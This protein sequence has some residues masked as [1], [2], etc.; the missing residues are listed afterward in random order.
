LKKQEGEKGFQVLG[1]KVQDLRNIEIVE[2]DLRGKRFVE[3]NGNNGAA[4]STLIDGLF[5]ALIGRKYFGGKLAWQVI[6]KGEDKAL[7]KVILGN[8]ER[9]IEV[10]R[11]ITKLPREGGAVETGGSLTITD[12]KGEKLDQDFLDGLLSELT[13]DPLAFARKDPREQVEVVK[14]LAGLD[15]SRLEAQEASLREERTLVN[16]ELK[17][18]QGAAMQLV[19]EPADPVDVAGLNDERR[20]MEEHNRVQR[21]RK[22]DFEKAQNKADGIRLRIV[23]LQNELAVQMEKGKAIE[24]ELKGLT[25]PEPLKP[26]DAVDAA[27][28]DAARQ[29]RIAQRYQEYQAARKAQE[30]KGAESEALSKKI[31]EVAARRMQAIK[32]AKLPFENVEFS[33]ELGLVIGG[34]PFSQ[35]SDAEKLRISTRIGM[36]LRPDF[37]IVF[38]REGS[39]LDEESYAVVRDLA[40]R[41]G[42]QV[43]VE[44]V[45]ERRG[46]E[47][48]VMRAG[49]AV[50]QFE[51]VETRAEKADRLTKEL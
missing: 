37:R 26:T 13:V 3:I 40:G 31:E 45:G 33:Q 43:L 46:E 29:N 49:E 28:A 9:E 21:E 4:K 48:I 14:R 35:K 5:G 20:A 1:L 19:C 18:A 11:S 10:K 38:V 7:M 6:R 50:S 23:D 51:R 42:Y 27:I 15:T 8:S 36:E 47:C 17:K 2:V 24:E 12:T 41:L 44:H 22:A 16:R 32:E 25:A 30:E 39:L 34:V